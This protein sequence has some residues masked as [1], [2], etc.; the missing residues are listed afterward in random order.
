MLTHTHTHTQLGT[1]AV[2]ASLSLGGVSW[3]AFGFLFTA[4]L[5]FGVATW[6]EYH[7]GF[8]HFPVINGAIEGLLLISGMHLISFLYGFCGGP[9]PTRPD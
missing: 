2:C 6:E 3:P 9:D 1:I 4:I 7:R 5:P 8:L